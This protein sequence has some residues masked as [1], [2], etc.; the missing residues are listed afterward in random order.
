MPSRAHPTTPN[1]LQAA[2]G[3]KTGI[4]EDDGELAKRVGIRRNV[5][6]DMFAEEDDIF[7]ATPPEAAGDAAA[8]GQVRGAVGMVFGGGMGACA[9]AAQRGCT[10]VLTPPAAALRTH[11]RPAVLLPPS[12]H[13]LPPWAP[14]AAAPAAAAVRKG[15]L[16]NYD[17]HEGYYNFQ[18]GEQLADRY[19]V[20]GA[21]WRSAARR[22]GTE[23]GAAQ[24][25]AELCAG[26]SLRS[27]CCGAGRLWT[28]VEAACAGC[29]ASSHM[30][31][32]CMR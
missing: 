32:A 30:S 31:R 5:D 14:Q 18:V 28:D 22:W 7:A 13:L 12:T 11:M 21:A 9:P 23:C 8:A 1:S 29:Y 10:G 17:D 25:G 4:G 19:E 27:L 26:G 15:L 20:R 24:G 16:D 3:T 6:V 2:A